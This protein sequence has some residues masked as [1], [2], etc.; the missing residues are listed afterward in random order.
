MGNDNTSSME[1]DGELSFG[2][3]A[4]SLS[5]LRSKVVSTW[6]REEISQ[7]AANPAEVQYACTVRGGAAIPAFFRCQAAT[8]GLE[9]AL[10]A[11]PRET[12]LHLDDQRALNRAR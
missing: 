9:V 6:L 1:R 2:G 5:E 8:I 12:S 3:S 11:L 7:R 10:P 4:A